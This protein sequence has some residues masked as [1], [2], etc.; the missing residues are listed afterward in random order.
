M[1]RWIQSAPTGD[2]IVIKVK[3]FALI[4][5]LAGASGAMAA[6]DGPPPKESPNAPG[7]CRACVEDSKGGQH[8]YKIPCANMPPS[9]NGRC[10]TKKMKPG[11]WCGV[12]NK[13]PIPHASPMATPAEKN[14]A[15]PAAKQ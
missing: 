3:V 1:E 2:E 9:T 4:L 5:M 14:I 11:Q 6:V 10:G 13:K 8:C 12:Q 7:D 15:A